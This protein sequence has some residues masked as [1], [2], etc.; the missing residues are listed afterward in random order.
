MFVCSTVEQT[1]FCVYSIEMQTSNHS[2]CYDVSN[3]LRFITKTPTF[4]NVYTKWDTFHHI[5]TTQGLSRGR[6][7]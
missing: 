6:L 2:P 4:K 7:N 1:V 5:P 3:R